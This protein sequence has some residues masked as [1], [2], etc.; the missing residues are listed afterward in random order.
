MCGRK[1]R[2]FLL[3]S[4]LSFLLPC[5]PF[6]FSCY[7]DVVLSNKEVEEMLNEIDASKKDLESVKTEL[8]VVK[9]TYKE[10]KTSYEMQLEEARKDKKV[11][12]SFAGI[13]GCTAT[14]LSI[15]LIIVLL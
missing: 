6:C 9:S 5:S 1:L 7:A 15:A 12:W 3:A 13:S 8:K 4:V 14:L 11:A 10:Q 2:V